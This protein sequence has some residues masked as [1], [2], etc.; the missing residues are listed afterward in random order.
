MNFLFAEDAERETS[1]IYVRELGVP[2]IA[3][4]WLAI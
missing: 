2:W 1:C 3:R 4:G